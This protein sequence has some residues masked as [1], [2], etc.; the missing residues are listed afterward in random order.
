MSAKAPSRPHRQRQGQ[1]PLPLGTLDDPQYL[2][3]HDEEWDCR[4]M[5]T[6][7]CLRC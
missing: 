2:R 1:A 6:A 4:G 3:Y 7:G 5:M